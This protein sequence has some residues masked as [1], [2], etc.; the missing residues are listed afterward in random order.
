M[1]DGRL[2]GSIS[3][4]G[5]AGCVGKRASTTCRL[6]Q[7]SCSVLVAKCTTLIIAAAFPSRRLPAKDQFDHQRA[8]AKVATAVPEL[9]AAHPGPLCLACRHASRG[10]AQAGLLHRSL[11]TN[12]YEVMIAAMAVRSHVGKP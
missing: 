8:I 11:T 9:A 3:V 6:T 4:M 1:A 5:L 10:L 12:D 2:C 7:Q